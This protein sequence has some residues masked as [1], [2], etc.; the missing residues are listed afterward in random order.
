[1]TRAIVVDASVALKWVIREEHHGQAR[2]LLPW[3]PTLVA[4]DIMLA[5]CA[6]VCRKKA[7][8]GELTRSQAVLGLETIWQVIP[9]FEPVAPLG[10]R[11]LELAL[12]LDH[13]AYD[14]I[15][16]ALA[17]SIGGV[18]VTADRTLVRKL[19]QAGTAI[20][21]MYIGDPSLTAQLAPG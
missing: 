9:R 4:P 16:L 18:L 19:D 1:V 20:V 3:A 2:E 11:A 15:Y 8:R 13:H 5:E 10:R 6:N 14:C 12:D 17:E 21:V 7:K